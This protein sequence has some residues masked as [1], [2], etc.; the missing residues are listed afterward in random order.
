MYYEASKLKEI[1]TFWAI[2]AEAVCIVQFPYLSNTHTPEELCVECGYLCIRMKDTT[3]ILCHFLPKCWNDSFKYRLISAF[4]GL[5]KKR[6][7]G[8]WSNPL[9]YTCP[10]YKLEDLCMKTLIAARTSPL[11]AW[12][13]RWILPDPLPKEDRHRW[14]HRSPAGEV[15][16]SAP[17]IHSGAPARPPRMVA[18][19]QRQSRRRHSRDW[20]V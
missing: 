12:P 16:G 5:V 19:N 20:A 14:R 9:V 3:Y 2:Y 6:H 4:G 7:E 11:D 17:K 15:R 10:F 8:Q 1:S 13:F 18:H